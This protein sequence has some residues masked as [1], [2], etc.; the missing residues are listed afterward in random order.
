M[1]N[2]TSY[3][4][5]NCTSHVHLSLLTPLRNALQN[6]TKDFSLDFAITTLCL[7]RLFLAPVQRNGLGLRFFHA[8]LQCFKIDK[9]DFFTPIFIAY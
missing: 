6:V 2:Y 4:S 8:T 3:D 7:T 9:E 1:M 5:R